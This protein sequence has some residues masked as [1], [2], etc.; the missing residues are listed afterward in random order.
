MLTF[1]HNSFTQGELDPT[2]LARFDVDLYTKGARKLRNTT[3]LWTGAARNRP[4]TISVDLIEDQTAG[5]D[6]ITNY[7]NIN[8]FMFEY[9]V[10]DDIIYAILIRPDTTDTTAFDIYFDD[11]L[12]ASVPAAM[13]TVAQ[14]KELKFVVGQ[15]RILIL[16]E[17]VQQRQLIRGANHATWTLSTLTLSI[18]PTYD[19]TIKGGTQYRI[20]G[21]TFTPAATTGTGINLTASGAIF[22]ANHI[23]G[24]F[25][26]LSN[27]NSGAMRITAVTNST[28][29]VG[30]IIDDF[31]A[32]AAIDGKE[33]SLNE[34]MWT[35]GGGVPVGEARGFPARGSFYLNR[36]IL[37]RSSALHNLGAFSS[38]AV[39]DDFDDSEIDAAS[40]FSFSL[41]GRGSDTIQDIVG[42]DA[43]VLIG[44]SRVYS[45]NPLTETAVT[46]ENFYAPPQ[47]G[48]GSSGIPS[49]TLDNQIFHVSKNRDQVSSVTYDTAK[50]R[51]TSLPAT[52][53]SSHIVEAINTNAGW[54][55]SNIQGKFYLATQDNGT[56]LILNTVQDH[57]IG[58]W[59]LSDTRGKFRR[60]MASGDLCM[61]VVE[62]Q[63]NTDTSFE[64]NFDH[65]FY[66][67]TLMTAF[68]DV[69]AAFANGASTTSVM[70]DVDTYLLFG[71]DVPFDKVKFTFGTPADVDLVLTF[72]YL[73]REGNWNTFS[74]TDGTTGF[75][76]NGNV[77]FNFSDVPGWFPNTVDFVES[78]Y[79][80]RI[81]RTEATVGTTPIVQEVEINTGIRIFLE[82]L[83]FDTFMDNSVNTSS[84]SSGAVTG[85]TELA[86]Q[87]VFAISD[88]ATYG[89]FFV[90][91][92]GT[93]NV[94]EEYSSVDIGM[95][96][97]PL[98][99][100][101]P[102]FA[103]T[104]EGDNL[105]KKRNIQ[106]LY[107]DYFES[108]Y[109][110]ASGKDIPIIPLG[111]YTLG[112][113]V[114]P[115][116]GVEEIQPMGGWD[117]RLEIEIRQAAPGPMTII[118]VGYNVEIS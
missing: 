60:I 12:Q 85:L 89:P 53:L 38:A 8:S 21:F 20:A 36:L 74:P 76:G 103:P 114:A 96:Y 82:R 56:L 93:T 37:G 50:A 14:I 27:N 105:Y 35:A 75:T 40:G 97:D 107:I 111:N 57:G 68:S 44:S 54:L 64:S 72:E 79:W 6:P 104:Q 51:Y 47:G 118:G 90:E 62:R 24:L 43:I 2:L 55:P 11:T 16:H 109:V 78:Q 67:D 22:T 61:A 99:V 63:I 94:T 95:K 29:A 71:N 65:A 28:V 58:A 15:D 112:T 52:L 91:S 69:T 88:G 30:D 102:T 31:T 113:P 13:Y 80:L 49:V 18:S 19:F 100:P 7:L 25:L 39:F 4:G 81:R 26:G 106:D 108:L 5:P 59:S 48:D 87:Q 46:A 101:M 9:D 1:T 77:T 41:A 33:S 17:D 42:D 66:T 70:V 32:A 34:V 110:T 73:D 83:D 23:G 86:G 3:A 116:T 45:T 10:D 92:D 98:I 115:Q 117:P 84:N